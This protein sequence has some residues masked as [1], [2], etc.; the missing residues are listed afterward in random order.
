VSVTFEGHRPFFRRSRLGFRAVEDV[1]LTLH[2]GQTL[3]IVGESGSGKTT[4]GRV[5]VG[6]QPGEGTVTFRGQPVRAGNA[7]SM[8]TLRRDLQIVF[9]DPYGSL[10]PRMT[11]GEIVTEG[12]LVHEPGTPRAERARRA[13]EV[14]ERVGLSAGMR[15]RFPHELSGGQRQRVAIARAIVLE[16]AVVVFDE[17]TSALDRSV[18][19]QIVDLLRDLQ[20]TLG[21]AY[22]FISHDLAVIRALADTVMVM[23]DGRVVEAAPTEALF[24]HPRTAYTRRLMEAALD[25]RSV[26]DA[27]RREPVAPG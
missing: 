10:S 6:L 16:P 22:I 19:K 20:A 17:P 14:L 26:V 7:G 18:Q 15:N 23:R 27:N 2:A 9:Q 25:P 11:V 12:L 13:G 1:S 21:L 4:L 3:G 5:L 24:E 8:K